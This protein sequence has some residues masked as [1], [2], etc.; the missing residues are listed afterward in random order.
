MHLYDIVYKVASH[1]IPY[2]VNCT[3]SLVLA[4]QAQQLFITYC[5]ISHHIIS[6]FP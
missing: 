4:Q 6:S 3:A 1:N 5:V 2:P